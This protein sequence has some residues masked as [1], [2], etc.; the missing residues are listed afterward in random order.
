MS[1]QQTPHPQA[2]VTPMESLLTV[3]YAIFPFSEGTDP[4]E[5]APAALMIEAFA[6]VAVFGFALTAYDAFKDRKN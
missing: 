3:L 5:L 4:I 2:I 1:K 6:A